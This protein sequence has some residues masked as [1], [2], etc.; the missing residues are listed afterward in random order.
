MD[1]YEIDRLTYA[2]ELAREHMRWTAHGDGN[3]LYDTLKALEHGN[4]VI[5]KRRSRAYPLRVSLL[6]AEWLALPV[7]NDPK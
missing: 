7:R 1:A 4:L 6:A 3:R 2:I 5:D